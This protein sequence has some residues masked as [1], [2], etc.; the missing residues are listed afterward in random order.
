MKIKV[1][2]QIF[3]EIFLKK[4]SVW[5]DDASILFI[6]NKAECIGS[7]NST[8][9]Y[10]ECPVEMETPLAPIRV[11]IRGLNKFQRAF[12]QIESEIVEL[13]L[14]SNKIVYASDSL[15]FVFHCADET[16][17]KK[18]LKIKKE[19]IFKDVYQTVFI[20]DEMTKKTVRNLSGFVESSKIYL[21]TNNEK[22]DLLIADFENPLSNSIRNCL[23]PTFSGAPIESPVPLSMEVFFSIIQ[24][25]EKEIK[26]LISLDKKISKFEMT[27]GSVKFVV[28]TPFLIK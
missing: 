6:E 20:C 27:V 28:M 2:K 18:V 17:F 5:T 22:V 23:S 15:N 4:I 26:I 3:S 9:F 21:V 10:A 12:S 8:Y 25:F 24:S 14:E 1:S 11:G 16:L 7:N 19:N 13:N